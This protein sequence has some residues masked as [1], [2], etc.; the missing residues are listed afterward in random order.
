LF[1]T[2][3]G[4]RA[5]PG[6][7][8][9]SLVA[10]VSSAPAETPA[11]VDA[12]PCPGSPEWDAAMARLKK[13]LKFWHPA[14][15]REI[16][17]LDDNGAFLAALY[18]TRNRADK[19]S[20]FHSASNQIGK[21][22]PQKALLQLA[23]DTAVPLRDIGVAFQIWITISNRNIWNFCDKN[24]MIYYKRKN[25]L[26]NILYVLLYGIFIIS[27]SGKYAFLYVLPIAILIL[28]T[29]VIFYIYLISAN[30]N[31]FIYAF[32]LLYTLPF[33]LKSKGYLNRTCRNLIIKPLIISF[34]AI[35]FA[36]MAFVTNCIIYSNYINKL[37]LFWPIV[38]TFT[39][40]V[41]LA[42]FARSPRY[43]FDNIDR[44]AQEWR[45]RLSERE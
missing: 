6:A 7:I 8:M 39:L 9:A 26:Q 33:K 32:S 30:L 10:E 41:T 27:I 22:S 29:T 38:I 13:K 12:A 3:P 28:L 21:E 25:L 11:R 16:D 20:L 31:R 42:L 23:V 18:T 5:Y 35:F 36:I 17:R 24:S 2:Q 44:L 34:S 15:S 45:D 4:G 1:F 19:L 40:P 37:T 14:L 43:D